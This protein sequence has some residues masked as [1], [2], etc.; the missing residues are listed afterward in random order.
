MAS[1]QITEELKKAIIA[2]YKRKPQTIKA[3]GLKFNL[4]GPTIMKILGDT[5]RYKKAQIFN[6]NLNEHFF[7]NID[8]ESKAYFLGLI[9]ADGNVFID[10]N[11]KNANR[12]AS[13]SITLDKKDA[14]L[15][16]E[17]KNQVQTN[18]VI[19]KDGRGCCC[20]AVR[21]N[22]MAQDLSKYGIIPRKTL[23]SYLPEIP[24]EHMSHLIR[25]ILDGDG[26]IQA[27]QLAR[28]FLHGIAFCGTQKLMEDIST[29]LTHHLQLKIKPKVYTYENKNL[30]EMKIQNVEDMYKLGMWLY[31]DATIYL[32]RK[33]EKF[34]LFTRHYGL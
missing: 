19:G 22:V 16:E 3:L 21:S 26:S 14:Y 23:F 28:R 24:I 9:I 10:E 27:S 30:S 5:E 17:F 1:K 31:N 18:T 8:C 32:K 12:Q 29:F 20:I 25:G 34:D 6:P 4:C 2:E 13:I 15:L 33:K 11:N 7:E